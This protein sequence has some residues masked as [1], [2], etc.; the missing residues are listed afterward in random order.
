[1]PDVDAAQLYVGAS[2]DSS[3]QLKTVMIPIRGAWAAEA[4][5]LGLQTP[6]KNPM[7]IVM[8]R[9]KLVASPLLFWISMLM[10]FSVWLYRWQCHCCRLCG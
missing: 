10:R 3:T 8:D 7:S 2:E 1:M 6:E 9:D 5:R 4:E